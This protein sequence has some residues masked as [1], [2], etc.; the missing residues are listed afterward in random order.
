V[1]AESDGDFVTITVTDEGPGLRRGG[2][3]AG[4]GMGL[5]VSA[6]LLAGHGGTLKLASPSRGGCTAE[7]RLPAAARLPES[8]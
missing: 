5:A 2:S 8:V 7:I 1:G 3:T 6:R 4:A